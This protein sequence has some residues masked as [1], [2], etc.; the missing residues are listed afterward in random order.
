MDSSL[1]YLSLSK[2]EKETVFGYFLLKLLKGKNLWEEE[3]QEVT[4][5]IAGLL[6]NLIH[7][8]NLMEAQK[9]LIVYE[10]DLSQFLDQSK[11]LS[12][13]YH[14][15]KFNADHL[16]VNHGIFNPS[17]GEEQHQVCIDRG[18]TYYRMTANCAQHIYR[19]ETSIVKV[20]EHLSDQFEDYRF[21]LE[22][23]RKTYLNFT[24]KLTQNEKKELLSYVH[25]LTLSA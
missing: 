12:E 4:V 20:F 6:L 2:R 17:G 1:I 24:Q 14:C 21:R 22:R 18:K 9:Y 19:K 8:S 11:D 10:S 25:N 15:L 3:N 13:Q 16:L 5:Y 7:P 23:L